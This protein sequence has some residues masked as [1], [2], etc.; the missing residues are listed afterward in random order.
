MKNWEL[1]LGFYHGVL[2]GVR[3]Y[4]SESYTTYV[5]YLPFIDVALNIDN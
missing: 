5:F 4:Y 2:F 1:S 3:T